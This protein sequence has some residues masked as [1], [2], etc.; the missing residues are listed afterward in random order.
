M[1]SGR[2]VPTEITKF[3]RNQREKTPTAL[4]TMY[5]Y[6]SVSILCIFEGLKETSQPFQ[7]EKKPPQVHDDNFTKTS[8]VNGLL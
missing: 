8:F 4:C 2:D 6:L 3:L 7:I 1:G 5:S